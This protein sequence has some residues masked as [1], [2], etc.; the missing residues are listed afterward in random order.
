MALVTATHSEHALSLTQWNGVNHVE[1]KRV[2]VEK[3]KQ[4]KDK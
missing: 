2:S 4:A 3:V 1:Q